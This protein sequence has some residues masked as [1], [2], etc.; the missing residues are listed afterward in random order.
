[1]QIQSIKLGGGGLIFASTSSVRL[2]FQFP[3]PI[4][5]AYAILR[6]TLFERAGE[7]GTYYATGPDEEVKVLEVS[8][9]ALFDA[10]QS[11]TGGQLQISFHLPSPLSPDVVRA[12]IEVLVIGI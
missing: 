9:L 10:L 3:T 1:M 11:R 2:P 6:S 12:E 7:R 8:A 5:G 4:D